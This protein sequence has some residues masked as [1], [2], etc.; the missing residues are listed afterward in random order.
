MLMMMMTEKK[1]KKRKRKRTEA[2]NFPT[3]SSRL[4][5]THADQ[6]NKRE[7]NKKKRQMST[8]W[9]VYKHVANEE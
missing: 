3:K 9:L 8:N 5:I 4:V 6:V 1:K 2:M 7:T